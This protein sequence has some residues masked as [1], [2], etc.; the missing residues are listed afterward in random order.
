MT[1]RISKLRPGETKEGSLR[2][3]DNPFGSTRKLSNRLNKAS[4][5]EER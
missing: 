1:R 2:K 5:M 3:K 4:D